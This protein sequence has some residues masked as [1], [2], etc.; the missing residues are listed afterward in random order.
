MKYNANEKKMEKMMD[1]MQEVYWSKKFKEEE[2]S[3]NTDEENEYIE[4]FFE[5]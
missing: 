4:S 2:G 3:M 5:I 1:K